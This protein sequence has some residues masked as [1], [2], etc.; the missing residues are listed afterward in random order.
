MTTDPLLF[1][2]SIVS[3]FPDAAVL[4]DRELRAVHYNSIFVSLTGLRHRDLQRTL[5]KGASVFEVLGHSVD[6][7]RR[8][9]EASLGGGR[10]I[11]L[12]EVRVQNLSGQTFTV[13]Q[14]FI[15]LLDE[16][17][18]AVGVIE[19]FRDVSAE[20]RMQ[21][22]YK[23]LLAQERARADDLERQVLQRTNELT[24]ALEEVTRLSLVDPLTGVLNRRAFTEYAE[25]ALS[26]ARRHDRSV[27][28]LMCDLDFFKKLNDTHGHQ[29]G[30]SIL[31]ATAQGLGRTVRQTDKVARFGGEEFLVLLTETLPEAVVQVAERCRQVV[32]DLPVGELVPGSTRR[33]TISIGVAV[34]PE[35][36][37]SLEELVGHADEALYEAKRLG[38]NR[39]EVY[40]P[41]TEAPPPQALHRNTVR[42]LIV[43]P[44]RGRAEAYRKALDARYEVSVAHAATT[45]LTFCAHEQFDVVIADQDLGTESGV[46]FLRNTQ[47]FLPGALRVLFLDTQDIFIAIRGTNVARVDFFLLRADGATHLPAAV[48][49]GLVRRELARQNLRTPSDI[50]RAVAPDQA[51]EIDRLITD[52]ALKLLYQPIVEV[53]SRKLFAYEA[54]CRAASV[55]LASPE[56]LFDAALRVGRLWKLGRTVRELIADGLAA[57]PDSC[58]VFVNLHPAEIRDPHLMEGERHLRAYASRVV[59]EL[60][61]R[62]AIPDFGCFLDTVDS[63]RALGY[64]FAVDDLGAGY[65]SLNSVALLGPDFIKID[66]SMVRDVDKAGRRSRLINRIVDFANGEGIRVIAEGVESEEEAVTLSDLG[67]HLLQGYHFG[68]PAALP[69]TS[70]D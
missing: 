62:A 7:D 29:A 27:G 51:D 5:A 11:H 15:P 50:L 66:R 25:Q 26:L 55:S 63:L 35:H 1:A 46:E 54:L 44:D 59:F 14:T 69:G 48:E 12:A 43:D 4:L 2:R 16:G 58:L 3:G 21:M 24:A 49:D 57:V 17:G 20:A 31:V 56:V 10:V 41:R 37:R 68:R 34:F 39:V 6:T 70:S 33:Q 42:A 32:Y 22:H 65:A 61:E 30:D 45:G 8:N 9:A 13:L 52:R 18:V 64:R 60:T 28:L 67:C 23:E 47:A 36:G 38:R 40:S 19:A 53:G